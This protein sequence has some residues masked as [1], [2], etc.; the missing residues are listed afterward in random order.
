MNVSQEILNWFHIFGRKNLPW[1]KNKTIYSV[2]ISEIMLQQTQV[3]TVIPYFIKFL[4]KYPT[5]NSISLSSEN[6]VLHK[7]SGLGYYKRAKNIYKAAKIISSKYNGQF[8]DVFNHVI[9]LPGIGKTTAGAILSIS[10]NYFF[11]ILDS[12]VKR[13]LIR[14]YGIK[15]NKY[16]KKIDNVLW[17]K[18]QSI[19]PLHNAGKFNQA[20]M[21]LG[22]LICYPKSPKCNICPINYACMFFQKNFF[23]KYSVRN[24]ILQLK[25]YWCIIIN[26]KQYIFLK[27]CKKYTFWKDLF[28]FP[29]FTKKNYLINWIKEEKIVPVKIKQLR[30]MTLY[31][32]RYKFII[33]PIFLII[34]T[35]KD[36]KPEKD[37][38]WFNLLNHQKVGI[39]SLVLKILDKYS[40]LISQ[41]N[42]SV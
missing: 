33:T 11:P 10:Y 25:N 41:T 29:L 32:T 17:K 42:Y 34:K 7:W 19:L 37:A 31:I 24:K 12:N 22:S 27:K 21:D 38:I 20:L 3:K 6:A 35:N 15:F 26:Y 16:N 8:P 18:I 14:L 28:C 9:K 1:Q 13:I 23:Q 2:W 4:K 40:H 36:F 39:P 5:I 30:S